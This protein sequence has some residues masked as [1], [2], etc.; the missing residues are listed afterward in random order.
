MPEFLD[1]FAKT[2]NKDVQGEIDKV[3]RKAEEKA[4]KRGEEFTEQ[5]KA[6][7]INQLLMDGEV[8]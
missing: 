2:E 3:V 8:E 1:R 4:K 6:D 7:L 5:Q